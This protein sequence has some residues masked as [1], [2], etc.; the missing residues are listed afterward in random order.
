MDVPLDVLPSKWAEL[1]CPEGKTDMILITDAIV[2][3]PDELRDRFTTWKTKSQAK[4]NTIVLGQPDTGDVESVS[5]RTW[6]VP[7]LDLDQ[8]PVIELMSL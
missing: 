3:I 2:S 4:L 5:D 8:E 6:L 7:N 1:G